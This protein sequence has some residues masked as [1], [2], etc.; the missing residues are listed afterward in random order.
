MVFADDNILI[1]ST[2]TIKKNGEYLV[3]VR[4][5]NALEVKADKSKYMVM[6]R[7]QNAVQSY[8]MKKGYSSFEMVKELRYLGNNCSNQNFIHEEIKIKIK[9]G[10]AV[11]HLVLYLLS[12]SL[13]SKNLKITIYKI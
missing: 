3:V 8:S 9:I 13:F 2:S 1:G 6:S 10:N 12:S 7:D 4:R 5:E 11:Y